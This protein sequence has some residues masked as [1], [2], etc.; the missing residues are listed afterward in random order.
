M[1][2]QK[3]TKKS[4]IGVVQPLF[5]LSFEFLRKTLPTDNDYVQS[6][7]NLDTALAADFRRDEKNIMERMTSDRDVAVLSPTFPV[8]GGVK[9][10]SIS[11]YDPNRGRLHP[12]ELYA[13]LHVIFEIQT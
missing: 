13:L 5:N 7:L 12:R 10:L 6:D 8:E 1:L 9:D 4:D 2:R 11:M 3:W